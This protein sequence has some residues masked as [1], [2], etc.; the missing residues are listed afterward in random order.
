MLEYCLIKVYW[1]KMHCTRRLDLNGIIFQVKI[2]HGK[3]KVLHSLLYGLW[4]VL[5]YFF[6]RI[7]HNNFDNSWK[8]RLKIRKM[9]RRFCRKLVNNSNKLRSRYCTK[10]THVHIKCLNA[11]TLPSALTGIYRGTR[12]WY[13]IFFQLKTTETNLAEAQK[14]PWSG[15][16]RTGK[17]WGE[18]MNDWN[19]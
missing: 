15:A 2:L 6:N 18:S 3:K 11:F 13:W 4:I 1:N 9:S 17:L 16:M 8:G 14:R 10:K 19:G 7:K 12:Y 5:H